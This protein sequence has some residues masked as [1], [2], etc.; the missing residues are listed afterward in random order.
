MAISDELREHLARIYERLQ[1]HEQTIFDLSTRIRSLE[2]ALR[3]NPSF[4]AL[5]L[6]AEKALENEK[7]LH[8]HA[9][10]LAE[11]DAVIRE[12]RNPPDSIGH[13]LN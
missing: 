8:E 5:L 12:L 13:R 4:A 7:M 6:A 9:A 3:T 2:T 1:S 11:Y 10:T